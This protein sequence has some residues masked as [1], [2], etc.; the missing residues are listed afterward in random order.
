[1]ADCADLHHLS[2][3]VEPHDSAIV[4]DPQRLPRLRTRQRFGEVGRVT[5]LVAHHRVELVES[6]LLGL[7]IECPE[8]VCRSLGEF[9]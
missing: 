3:A 1:M 4:A 6:S 8:A 7:A 5:E 2:P 9:S